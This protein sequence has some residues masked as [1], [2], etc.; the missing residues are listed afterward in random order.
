M[1]RDDRA[2]GIGRKLPAF[3]MPAV[4]GMTSGGRL[5]ILLKDGKG[6]QLHIAA[7][8]FPRDPDGKPFATQ[9]RRGHPRI[10]RAAIADK[11]E[12]CEAGQHH[13]P[14][15][16]LWNGVQRHEAQHLA[17]TRGGEVDCLQQTA[18]I[19][20]YQSIGRRS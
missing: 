20:F 13:R 11:A 8:A 4:E 12:A 16:R 3:V 18:F 5:R 19:V 15:F 9:A 2:F 14:G 1:S 10:A 6:L 17:R 7:P